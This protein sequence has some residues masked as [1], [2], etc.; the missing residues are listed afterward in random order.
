MSKVYF[1]DWESEK[2]SG[3]VGREAMLEDFS[4]EESALDGAEILA[5]AYT[6]EDYSGSAY[7]LFRKDGKLFAVNGGHCSCFGLEG[8]WEPEEVVP[9]AD[10]NFAYSGFGDD[11]KA[12]VRSI[13]EAAE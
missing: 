10:K 7:V 12:L 2:W 13:I 3:K 1:H 8:Q 5:A 9:V 6:Y 11:F 4:I